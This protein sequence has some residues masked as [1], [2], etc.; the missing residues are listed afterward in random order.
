[1]LIVLLFLE[2]QRISKQLYRESGLSG[3]DDGLFLVRH[4][5][6]VCKKLTD[7]DGLFLVRHGPDVC[8]SSLI[9]VF[10]VSRSASVCAKGVPMLYH[11]VSFQATWYKK[12]MCER[13]DKVV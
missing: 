13:K 3:S 9:S 5:P 1:M 7:D 6:D 2:L 4:W 12:Y 8:K 10:F 11:S